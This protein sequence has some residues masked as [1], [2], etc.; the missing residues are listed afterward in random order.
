[1]DK[2]GQ[3]AG[4]LMP[5]FTVAFQIEEKIQRTLAQ[6]FSHLSYLNFYREK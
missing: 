4:N 5:M 6:G 1:L 3:G 2:T